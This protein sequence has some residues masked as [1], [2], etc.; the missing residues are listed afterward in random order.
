M[1]INWT[2]VVM[3][4][5]AFALLGIVEADT[6]THT[7]DIDFEGGVFDRT[8]VYGSGQDA[9]IRSEF[10][11]SGNWDEYAGEIEERKDHAMVYDSGA[12]RIIVF[13]GW[14]E[15]CDK[16]DTWMYDVTTNTWE[17]R[18]PTVSPQGRTDHSMVYHPEAERTVLFGGFGY[19]RNVRFDDTWTYDSSTNTWEDMDPSIAPSHRYGHFMVYDPSTDVIVLFGGYDRERNRQLN[20]TWTYDIHSNTWTELHPDTSP[21]NR[22]GHVMAYDPYEGV[23]VLFGGV[24]TSPTIRFNDTW[25]FNVTTSTWTETS[26]F[27]S[28]SQRYG[29]A[30]AYY[31]SERSLAIHGGRNFVGAEYLWFY[32]A[33]ND[34]WTERTTA[35]HPYAEIDH[36]M[37][38]DP[39]SDSLIVFGG[40]R[41]YEVNELWSYNGTTWVRLDPIRWPSARYG[42]SLVYARNEEVNILFGGYAGGTG[43]MNDTWEYRAGTRTWSRVETTGAPRARY[44]HRACY[45][46]DEGV[47]VVFGGYSGSTY[48]HDTWEYDPAT[49]TWENT[50][51]AEHPSARYQHNMAYDSSDA[52]C[53]MFGGRTKDMLYN[54]ETWMYNAGGDKWK[55]VTGD[56]PMRRVAHSMAYHGSIGNIVVYGG[57][58]TGSVDFQDT[59]EFDSSLEQWT[60][61]TPATSPGRRDFNAMVYDSYNKRILMYGSSSDDDKQLKVW[62]YYDYLG[63]RYWYDANDYNDASVFAYHAASYDSSE[64]AM[65]I[66]GGYKNE[67]LD[68]TWHYYYPSSQWELATDYPSPMARRYG[69]MVYSREEDSMY[70][71]GGE[72]DTGFQADIWRFDLGSK[73]WTFEHENDHNRPGI[74]TYTEIDYIPD[75]GEIVLY[76]GFN[77]GDID[78]ALWFYDTELHS[79]SGYQ[80]VTRPEERYRTGMAYDADRKVVVV[81]GGGQS[82]MGYRWNDTWEFDIVGNEWTNTTPSFSPPRTYDHSM[83]WDPISGKVLMTGGTPGVGSNSVIWAYDSMNDTWE[84]FGRGPETYNYEIFVDHQTGL[85]Y[86]FGGLFNEFPHPSTFVWYRETNKWEIID[87]LTFPA[88]KSFH[89][90]SYGFDPWKGRALMFGGRVYDGG[91]YHKVDNTYLLNLRA[92]HSYGTYTSPVIGNHAEGSVHWQSMSWN[93]VE[94]PKDTTVRMQICVND[95][96]IPTDFVGPDGSADTYYT[97]PLGET[98]WDGHSG[99]NLWYRIH[100]ESTDGSSTATVADVTIVYVTYDPP[101]AALLSPNGGEDLMESGSHVITWSTSGDVEPLVDLHFTIDGGGTWTTI[102]TDVPNT[103]YYNWTVPTVESATALVRVT[104]YGLEGSQAMDVSDMTF[105]IDPPANWQIPGSGDG[106]G[107]GTGGGDQPGTPDR[108]TS[109][110]DRTEVGPLWLA[111]SIEAIAIVALTLILIVIR[112]ERRSK[113]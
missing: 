74:R 91:D 92:H 79:W 15:E 103:G 13:G 27:N 8:E 14:D 51:S 98:L 19:N 112:I 40:D 73:E 4:L 24:T 97:N 12:D 88:F 106:T 66:F 58:G 5:F 67:F 3:A 29:S 101:Q 100:F 56:G 76:G 25:E 50:T 57:Y 46:S 81:F 68:S 94:Q 33:S 93:P 77:D 108:T 96:G 31:P 78:G 23:V 95:E 65:I 22:Y 71:F 7:S 60:N 43:N 63:T 9:V 34:T 38:Y 30:A 42:H 85:L 48:M 35:E 10:I 82:G 39:I 55:N 20:D 11:P 87:P 41:S 17:L 84:V 109:S 104:V 90:S 18:N 36:Q 59:W 107:D 70:L 102:A 28:P 86:G 45:D 83:C 52:S 32:N 49:R 69:I 110:E 47:I 6:I 26:P 113:G 54:N 1:R 99:S 37:V 72:T 64:R 16:D 105:A 2:L 111:I 53:V 61:M 89:Y 62:M 21:V 80:P 44:L 75:T